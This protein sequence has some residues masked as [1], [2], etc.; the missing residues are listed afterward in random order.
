MK[1]DEIKRYD[2]QV[3]GTRD[4]GDVTIVQNDKGDLVY[5][6]EMRLHTD[7]Q[8]TEIAMLKRRLAELGES[9]INLHAK[10]I[11]LESDARGPEPYATWQEAATAE[12]IKRVEAEKKIR[13]LEGRDV[14]ARYFV[15]RWLETDKKHNWVGFQEGVEKFL[16]INEQMPIPKNVWF[17]VSMGTFYD[18][19][20][21]FREMG[22]KFHHQWY[23]RRAEFPTYKRNL[24]GR[25]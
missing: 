2:I 18:L 17:N 21:D 10:I 24:V 12:R 23:H 19:F 14:Q 7:R 1:L 4:R 25:P 13:E 15:G 6:Y 16:G 9:E 22:E 11:Q 8:D 3:E 5:Y 20:Y